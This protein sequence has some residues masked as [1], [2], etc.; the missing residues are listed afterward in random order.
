MN[1]KSF[2]VSIIAV[3]I[4]FAGGFILANALNRSE[5]EVL[6]AENSRLKTDSSGL[7][8]AESETA[9]S[10][11][12]IRQRIIEAEQNPDN[13][14]FQKNFGLALYRYAVIKQDDK[15]LAEV[16]KI[17]NR[18]YLLNDKDYDVLVALGNLQF[19]F[20]YFKKSADGFSKAR[21][22]YAK[23]LEQN[24]NDVDVKTDLGLTYFLANPPQLEKAIGEFKTSL[25][26][27]PKHEK[28]LQ[29]ITQSYIKAGNTPEAEIYLAR[30]KEIN[31]QTPNL[32][33]FQ[34]QMAAE[35]GLTEKQ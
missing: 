14:S 21:E 27:N 29:F 19:D 17:L 25:G 28:T 11:G 34:T 20:G 12:E 26:I 4:S 18:A 32:E 1:R 5:M 22:F 3:I 7:E 15:M 13:F 10:E 30:L 24:P 9:L 16:E 35:A 33:M 2:W 6:R 31:P 8:A 23:A